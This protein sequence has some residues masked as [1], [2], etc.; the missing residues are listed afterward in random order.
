MSVCPDCGK[1]LYPSGSC[2]GCA[3]RGKTCAARSVKWSAERCA[4]QSERQRGNQFAA[5]MKH[6]DVTRAKMSAS[7]QRNKA[8]RRPRRCGI[9]HTEE[10]KRKM[11]KR[12]QGNKHGSGPGIRREAWYRSVYG[13]SE[14]YCSEL[15]AQQDS[16]CA[17][18]RTPVAMGRDGGAVVDHEHGRRGAACVRGV[19]CK[20]CNMGLGSFLDSLELMRAAAAYI[21]AY[22]QREKE[23]V[24]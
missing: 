19:L 10:W 12:M 7:H 22:R 2:R 16:R 4:E 24:A 18:C 20:K 3:Q 21:E 9:L 1:Q 11:S 15:L 8:K 6:S 5:G 14:A 23:G 17:I 13:V